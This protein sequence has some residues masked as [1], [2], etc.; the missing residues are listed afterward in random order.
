MGD[1]EETKGAITIEEIEELVKQDELEREPVFYNQSTP[2]PIDLSYKPVHYKD[3]NTVDIYKGY[4]KLVEIIEG[5]AKKNRNRIHNADSIRDLCQTWLD[6]VRFRQDATCF[7]EGRRPWWFD[8][9]KYWFKGQ[10]EERIRFMTAL[11]TICIDMTQRLNELDGGPDAD[12]Q[13]TT[14][15]RHIGF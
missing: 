14:G 8:R 12:E 15:D 3:H 10:L 13:P 9:V 1:N 2:S 11:S 5:D 6:D 7:V 4:A